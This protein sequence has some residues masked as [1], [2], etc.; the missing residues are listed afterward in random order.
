MPQPGHASRPHFGFTRRGMPVHLHAAD[1]LRPPPGS[2]WVTRAN[3]WLAL[4]ITRAVGTMWCAYAFAALDL[5]ALPTAIHGGLYGIV[6]WTASFFLQLV[7]LSIIMVG[8]A[9]Q[10]TASDARAAKTF[11]DAEEAR[12]GI[13][14]ALDRLDVT[15]EG[16]LREVLDALGAQERV[17]R[18][19][20][21]TMTRPR[22]G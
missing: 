13:A 12:K 16:G 8:Q 18:A 14:V 20:A 15:T 2:P 6:Q 7:L 19:L 11:E 1:H 21:A 10:A 4:R 22:G 9:V 3:A 17:L 5:L